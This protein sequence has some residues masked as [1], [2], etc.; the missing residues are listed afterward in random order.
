MYVN[1]GLEDVWLELEVEKAEEF[2]R[3]KLELLER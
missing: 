1:L 3:R 2:V